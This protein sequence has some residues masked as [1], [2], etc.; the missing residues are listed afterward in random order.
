MDA[1]DE[2]RVG[3]EVGGVVDLVL[4]QDA[5]DLVAD[6]LGRVVGVA[7]LEQKVVAQGALQH[8]EHE[9]AAGLERG[10]AAGAPPQLQRVGEEGIFAGGFLVLAVGAVE[11]PFGP[12]VPVVPVE[13]ARHGEVAVLGRG[14]SAVADEGVDPVFVRRDPAGV[15]VTDYGRGVDEVGPVEAREMGI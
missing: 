2:F 12:R 10:V 4:E 5:R 1:V 13:G 3:A 7:G 15:Q 11:E 6:E 14:V 9:A 8:G